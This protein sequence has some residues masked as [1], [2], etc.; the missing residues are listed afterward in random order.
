M[1]DGSGGT[2]LGLAELVP[3]VEALKLRELVVTAFRDCG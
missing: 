1:N 2:G 3:A